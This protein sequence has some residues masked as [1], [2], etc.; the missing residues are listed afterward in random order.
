MHADEAATAAFVGL[1][2]RETAVL[3]PGYN[4][5]TVFLNGWRLRY[6]N[7]D[8]R[9]LGFGSAIFNI[10][11]TQN[12]D[13]QELH[14]EAGGVLSDF[15]GDDP[16]EWCGI[17]TLLFWHRDMFADQLIPPQIAAWPY[18]TDAPPEALT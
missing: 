3:P 12:G 11:Q 1:R 15:N 4:T 7:G 10:T 8:H 5:G 18:H 2:I 13:Q 6:D 17:Y 14:W 16:Y 9:M